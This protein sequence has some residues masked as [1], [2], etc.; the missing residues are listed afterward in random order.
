[1]ACPGTPQ[2]RKTFPNASSLTKTTAK[3][4]QILSTELVA[5]VSETYI[6]QTA[7]KARDGKGKET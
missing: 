2:A 5:T 7:D 6:N 1:M 4:T 3:P